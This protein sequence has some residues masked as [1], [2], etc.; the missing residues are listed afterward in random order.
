MLKSRPADGKARPKSPRGYTLEAR[1]LWEQVV[2]GWD[3]DPPATTILDLA[4][5]AL[6]RIREAQQLI[7]RD[8]L[9][10]TD[11][12]GQR[13]PNPA[14]AI[15]RDAKQT[16]LRSLRALNL[17]LEPL[18]DGPGRPPRTR[19]HPGTESPPRGR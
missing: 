11:R 5:H 8:G 17:D 9:V 2:E 15:E 1:R 7:A 4:C 12:F 13:K 6:Q 18:R 3:L 10:V 16:L 14:A 19:F